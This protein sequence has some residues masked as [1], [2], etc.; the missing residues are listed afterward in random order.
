MEYTINLFYSL[1]AK[2][3]KRLRENIKKTRKKSGF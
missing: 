3:Q 1:D 2:N